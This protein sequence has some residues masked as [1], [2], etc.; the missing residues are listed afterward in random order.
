MPHPR[1]NLRSRLFV[2]PLEARD[3]PATLANLGDFYRADGHTVPLLQRIDQV[4]VRLATDFDPAMTASGGALA[5]LELV[6][7]LN[8]GLILQYAASPRKDSAEAIP[9]DQR[10]GVTWAAPVFETTDTHGYVIALESV[11]VRLQPGVTAE[12]FFAG[13]SRFTG[14]HPLLGTPDQFTADLTT[15]PGRATLQMAESLSSDSRLVWAS[16]ALAIESH[17][18][19]LDSLYGTQWHLNNTGQS[20]GGIADSDIDAPEAWAITTG[21][22]NIV[23]ADIDEGIQWSHPDLAANVWSPPGEIANNSIDDDGNGWIDDTHGWDT[24]GNDNDPSP[25]SGENH[26]TATAGLAV[27]VGD[28]SLGVAGVAYTSKLMPIRSNIAPALAQP[29]NPTAIYYAAGRTADG[30]G[31]WRGADIL[32][33]SWGFDAAYQPM[34]DA[35][36][37]A[38]TNGR[39]GKG[40]PIFIATGNNSSPVVGYP[41]TLSATL[42]GVMAVGGSSNADIRVGYSQFGPE[43]DF[44]APTRSSNSQGGIVTTDRTG[45]VGYNTADYTS[46]FSGTSASTPIAAGVGALVLS[47]DPNLT[48][49]QVRGLL[50]NTTDLIGP[51]TYGTVGR[52]NQYGYGRLNA[53]TAV[54]GVGTRK[55]QLFENNSAI[56]SG[57]GSSS[58]TATTAAP[59]TKTYRIRNQGTLDLT[60]GATT[61]SAGA[62]S[63][64]TNFADTTLSVGESTTLSV[65]FTPTTGGSSTAT[66][67]FATNDPTT[68][69]YSMTL[70][71]SATDVTAPTVN[72]FTIGDGSP[73]R[74]LIKS[75]G[76]T[77]SEV[78]TTVGSTAA[79]FVLTGP[80]ATTIPLNVVLPTVSGHTEAQ[81]TFASGTEFGSLIDG[82][83]TLQVIGGQIQDAANNVLAATASTTFFRLFGDANGDHFTSQGDYNQFMLTYLNGANSVFDFNDN[84]EVEQSDYNEFILRFNL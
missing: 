17:L 4:A 78:V 28:N 5:G 61:I 59:Q 22:P 76:V 44:V 64:T 39:G 70:N 42:S 68:P 54:Q 11:V 49:S 56:T 3:V 72:G 77:F 52:N 71:G 20:T 29:D 32:T 19:S 37:W 58:F 23:V 80:G 46:T 6:Q 73:Q 38:S 66:L 10:P 18:Y 74:S 13:D 33:C 53:A 31:T 35:F 9:A 69:T 14:I 30:L 50:H 36:A 12:A 51:L 84:A 48:A 75:L 8:G 21:S 62:F 57:S 63:V 25:A 65:T 24:F 43:V 47:M 27:A 2:T 15:A 34:N 83:Y 79:A 67:S 82:D 41:A 16:P 45:S 40:L 60:L 7:E 55:I 81:I 26:G 1:R